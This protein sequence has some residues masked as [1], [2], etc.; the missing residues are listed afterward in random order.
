MTE[1]EALKTILDWLE[2]GEVTAPADLKFDDLR[3][4]LAASFYLNGWLFGR[5]AGPLAKRR[6][7]LAR[8]ILQESPGPA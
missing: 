2:R 3:R 8:Q 4:F 1:A 7:K 5:V 6:K